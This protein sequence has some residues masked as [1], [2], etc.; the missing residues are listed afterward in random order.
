MMCPYCV[1]A[2]VAHRLYEV[3][4]P[5]KPGKVERFYENGILHVHD[6][7]VRTHVYTCT[8]NHNFK[9]KSESRCTC[10]AC[11]W[12]QRPLVIAGQKGLEQFVTEP[13][14]YLEKGE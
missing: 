2:G 4:A 1:R 7:T 9:L 6:H 14:A 5:D 12:N 13:L 10:L 3:R 11:D 8:H